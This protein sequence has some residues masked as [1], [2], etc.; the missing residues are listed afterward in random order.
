MHIMGTMFR[1]FEFVLEQ[2][3][4]MEMSEGFFGCGHSTEICLV[5]TV[6]D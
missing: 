4:K 6:D 1:N 2:E 5:C 3:H